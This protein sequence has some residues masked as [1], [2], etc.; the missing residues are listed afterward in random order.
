MNMGNGEHGEGYAMCDEDDM[1]MHDIE[2]MYNQFRRGNVALESINGTVV[3][4]IDRGNLIVVETD[5][6][7]TI[8]VKIL[9]TYIDVDTGYLTSGVW[10]FEQI[11]D[12]IDAGENVSVSVIGV[13]IKKVTPALG[14]TIDG[15]DTYMTPMLYDLKN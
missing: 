6:G 12:R 13:G 10:L 9:G 1:P 4:T 7:E 5:D 2:E 15:V 3:E 11:D 8:T 14:I